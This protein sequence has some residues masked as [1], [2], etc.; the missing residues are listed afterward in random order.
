MYI[1]ERI[2]LHS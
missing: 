2:F 1:F